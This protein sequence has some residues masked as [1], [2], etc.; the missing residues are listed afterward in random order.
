ML[1]Q[2]AASCYHLTKYKEAVYILK[3]LLKINPT[4]N[5]YATFLKKCIRKDHPTFVKNS[6]A[7]S[8]LLFLVSSIVIFAEVLLIR[9]F[10]QE[11]ESNV[12][13]FRNTLFISAWVF[14][15]GGDMLNRLKAKRAVQKFLEE[16][17]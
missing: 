7:I 9:T 13:V 1:F 6:R 3:E 14:L 17:S 11:F 16:V 4:D 10:Y 15:I 5:Y 2:K 12:E 8:V